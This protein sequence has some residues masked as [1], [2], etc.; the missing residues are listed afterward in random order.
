MKEGYGSMIALNSV[1]YMAGLKNVWG[2]AELGVESGQ[3]DAFTEQK[4]DDGKIEFIAFK[5]ELSLGL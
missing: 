3:L 1:R 5:N 2:T 4:F